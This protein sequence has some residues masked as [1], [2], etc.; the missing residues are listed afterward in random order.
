MQSFS[1]EQIS[2]RRCLLSFY[3]KTEK[4]IQQQGGAV[5]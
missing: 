5:T 2:I 1:Q 3:S 4:G